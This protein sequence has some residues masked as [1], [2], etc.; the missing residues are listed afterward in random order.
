MCNNN[1]TLGV[2]MCN[3][4]NATLG[5]SMCNNNNATLGLFFAQCTFLS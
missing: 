2:S 4:N 3:N 1:A 5:V